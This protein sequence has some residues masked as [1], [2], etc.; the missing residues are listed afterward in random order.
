MALRR[1]GRKGAE[2]AAEGRECCREGAARAWGQ[3]SCPSSEAVQRRA[4]PAASGWIARPCVSGPSGPDLSPRYL[5]QRPL[6]SSAHAAP[7]VSGPS[8]HTCNIEVILNE[9]LGVT[10]NV[11]LYQLS[12]QVDGSSKN[13]HEIAQYSFGKHSS[14]GSEVNSR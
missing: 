4:R 8:L 12:Q 10:F 14:F 3:E 13:K 6:W 1:S 7:G 11:Y 2:A 5:Q 9:G